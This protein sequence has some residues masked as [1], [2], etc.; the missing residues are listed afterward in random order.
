M[1][2]LDRLQEGAGWMRGVGD[3]EEDVEK[4]SHELRDVIDAVGRVQRKLKSED[5]QTADKLGRA[6]KHMTEAEDILDSLI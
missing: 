6:L 4:S 1:S 5:R 2:L 3:W